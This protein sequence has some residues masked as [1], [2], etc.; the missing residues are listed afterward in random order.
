MNFWDSDPPMTFSEEKWSYDKRRDFRYA[1][2]D[3]LLDTVNFPA[4]YKKKVLCV[5]EGG[6]IDA[7]EFSLGG[8]DV[9]VIDASE[10]AIKL[11]SDLFKDHGHKLHHAIVGD[12]CKMPLPDF[13]F[14]AVY[15]CGVLHHILDV[16][17]AVSEALR[18]LKP[19]GTYLG[20]VYNA[21]SLLYAYSI[22]Q[23]GRKEGISPD[24]AMRAY[25]ERRPGCPHSVSYTKDSLKKL[26]R[27][28]DTV[29]IETKYNVVDLPDQRKVRF[30]VPDG[31]ELG[32]HLFFRA[33]KRG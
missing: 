27:D 10:N 32:W 29:E 25:S 3:Y 24:D 11:T 33:K 30:Q 16:N 19:G 18:V 20:L 13:S 21:D 12:A 22:V 15:C 5:G 8:A 4:F 14:D 7:M 6:G 31:I 17:K 28:F 9:S 2:V 26:L 1:E 23:R